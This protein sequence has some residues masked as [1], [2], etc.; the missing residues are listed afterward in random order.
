[1]T[2]VRMVPIRKGPGMVVLGLLLLLAAWLVAAPQAQAGDFGFRKPITIDHTKVGNS[3]ATTLTN[4]PFLYSV[5]DASLKSTANGGHV[6]NANGWDII[7]RA[8]DADNPGTG[9]NICGAGVSV[10]TLD[11]EIESYDPTTGKLVAWVR[12]PTLKA[13][14]YTPA[15]LDTKIYIYYG[16][17]TIAGSTENPTGVWDANYNAV[18]HLKENPAGAA[19]QMKDSTTNALHATSI[20]SMTLSE[21]VAGKINGSLSFNGTSNALNVASFTI[22]TTF[23][24]E[25]WVNSNDISAGVYHAYMDS[26]FLFGNAGHRWL[27]QD[28]SLFA[29]DGQNTEFDFGTI[30]ANTWYHVVATYDNTQPPTG[31]TLKLYVNGALLSTQNPPSPAPYGA[32]TATFGLAY[33]RAIPGEYFNGILDEARVS[34][35]VRSADWIKA[36]YNNINSPSTFCTPACGTTTEESNPPSLVHFTKAHA[37]AYDGVQN[38]VVHLQWRT[39][40]EVD[41]LGFHVY[42]E[43]NGERLQVTP[44]LIAGSALKARAGT[45]LT[46]GQSYSWWDVLPAGGG[47]LAYWLEEIDLHGQRTWHGPVPVE[48]AKGHRLAAEPE[49]VRSVLLTRMGRGKTSVTAVPWYGTRPALLGPVT[50]TPEQ[51]AVQWRLAAGRAVKLGV[52]AEGWYHV[53][54]AELVAAGLDAR[55]NPR[56][57]H[58]Y[59]DGVEVP[60]LVLGEHD[61]RFDPSD[62][63]EF[64]GLGLDTPWT[65]TRTYWLVAESREGQ[66]VSWAPSRPGGAVAPLS[67]PSTLEWRPR[68]I[69]FAALLNGEA[70]NYFGPVVGNW[71]LDQDFTL[72]QLD[73]SPSGEGRLE[74]T[75]QGLMEG[76]HQVEVRLNGSPVGTVS[77]EGLAQGTTQVRLSPAQLLP[78]A[79][80]VTLEAQGGELDYSLVASVRLTYWRFYQA[81]A[82]LLE[83][84]APGGDQVTISGFSSA[85]IRVLDVTQP[86]AVQALPGRVKR[87]RSGFTVTVVAPGSGN[88]TLLAFTDGHRASPAFLRLH[89]PSQWHASGPGADL[90]ILT[91]GSFLPSLASLQAWRQQQGWAVALIDVD[92]V[93]DEFSFGAK[94]PWA[95]RAFLQQ[96]R[97]TWA[98]PPR[99]LLLAGD[100]SVDPRNYMGMGEMDFVPTKLVDT[101]YLETASDDWFGDLDGDGVPE[102]AVGRLAVQTR[103]Q[104]DAVVRKLIAYDQAG[105][106]GRAAVLVADR[107]DGYDFEGASGQVKALLPADAT[108]E[109]IYRAQMGDDTARAALLSSLNGGPWLVNYIGHG[110]VE[111]WLGNLLSSDDAR[112]LTNG[113]RLPFVVAMTCLNGFFHDVFTES[114]AET[115]QK[116]PQG[117]AV[118]VWAS[119]ALTEPAA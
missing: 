16:A 98:R 85:Q 75:L 47:P 21:Q 46:A 80:R 5:T 96:V 34:K 27:G 100:A 45:V 30:S 94:S 36:E 62:A 44:A 117:G 6:Q 11:H 101:Q 39:S 3:G 84:A 82:D 87:E 13:F 72:A 106:G 88:R 40:Y 49:R 59:A 93:Y 112:A 33:T 38:R 73:P 89:Q 32:V 103:E 102:I 1:M 15:P 17:S 29:W 109:E 97:S 52:Q 74:V 9:I 119:S 63:I 86:D 25:T 77:F 24:L 26:N 92:A 37:L 110:S 76:R 79:N 113:V 14:S 55:V 70:D 57:L 99:F 61:G 18:W 51:L 19:P 50:P 64:Y 2:E 66:R 22:G 65:D 67:F 105:A 53:S 8:F 4:Y 83:A 42:R 111:V 90:V 107:N 12:I 108:V 115:L 69:Y 104:A 54:Q 7:F 10:C 71:P 58:L 35:V 20:G 41:H 43:Q 95:L 23:T 68:S 48:S 60:L 28:G 91:H 116:A 56:H 81:E 31:G 114:L 78:G 118:A